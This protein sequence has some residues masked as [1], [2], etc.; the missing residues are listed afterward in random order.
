MMKFI[1]SIIV[2]AM[3]TGLN[4]ETLSLPP[5]QIEIQDGWEYSVEQQ[6]GDNSRSIIS[7]RDPNGAG[8][9]RIGS[10]DA[11]TV[12]TRDILRTMTNVESSTP[13]AWQDWGDFSGYQ[14]DY[15]EGDA[16]LRQWWLTNE[17][18]I[19]FITYQCDPASRDIET[20]QIDTVVRSIET[21]SE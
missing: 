7:L 5:I 12:V 6:P 4:A 11:P 1:L 14:Y 2:S 3:A 16:F 17:T 20:E 19:I 10:Y 13:L 18:I 15:L 9:T 8:I 21:T